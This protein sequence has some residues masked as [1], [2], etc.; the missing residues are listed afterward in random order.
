VE[1]HIIQQATANNIVAVAAEKTNAA[2]QTPAGEKPTR[3]PKMNCN[4]FERWKT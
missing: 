4:G 1:N 2:R 3:N